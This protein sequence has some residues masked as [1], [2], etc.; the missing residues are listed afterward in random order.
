MLRL[1]EDLAEWRK[2]HPEARR[3]GFGRLIRSASLFED[4]VKTI[5]GCNVTWRNTITMNRLMA[6]KFG[7]GAFPSPAELA[8]LKPSRLKE[9]ARVGY[10]AERIIGLA[11]RFEE[12]S[13]DAAW[14]ESA[15][16]PTEEL[17]EGLLAIDGFGPYATANM[18]QLLG[19][20]DH[21]PIDTET[22]R[23]YCLRYNVDRPA[24]PTVLDAQI[25]AHYDR[26]APYQFLA[27][28]F[29]L[30]R[31]YERRFGNAWTWDPDTAAGN[32]TA[33]VLKQTS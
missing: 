8:R 31:D 27:Y 17:R 10:R 30:W 25:R 21:V 11:R 18:L 29:D 1:E 26:Y 28:W 7:E 24:K 19:R 6:E 2:L 16:R 23:H 9:I 4:M 15:G 14:F 33:S 20:Y 12:G 13:L 22:Y 3:R 5:T 32:F